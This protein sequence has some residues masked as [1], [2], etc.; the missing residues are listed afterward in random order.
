MNNIPYNEFVTH[1]VA[2]S[3]SHQDSGQMVRK[4]RMSDLPTI[5]SPFCI[6]M[7]KPSRRYS[8]LHERKQIFASKYMLYLPSEEELGLN[9]L[10]ERR[11]I[12]EGVS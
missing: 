4:V 6:E 1:W 11:L 7:N 3:K 8:I 5:D 9:I 2:N 12:E 10:M